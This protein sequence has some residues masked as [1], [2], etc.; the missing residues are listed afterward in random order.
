LFSL[1]SRFF[2]SDSD[3]NERL[4]RRKVRIDSKGRISIPSVLR[5]NFGLEEGIEIELLFN[6]KKNFLVLI[7]D[8]GQ[9]GVD[10]STVGCGS[11]GPGSNP[12]PGP[13]NISRR[14]KNAI[15]I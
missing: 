5:K 8:N 6:L 14:C 12:G 1:D 11:A 10:G 4:T 3:E 9:D 2:F 13:E 15:K 7:L